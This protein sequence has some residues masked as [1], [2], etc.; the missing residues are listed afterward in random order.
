MELCRLNIYAFDGRVIN[1]ACINQEATRPNKRVACS[2]CNNNKFYSGRISIFLKLLFIDVLTIIVNANEI[3]M[4]VIS[5][6]IFI[7]KNGRN[8]ADGPAWKPNE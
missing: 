3:W 6:N 8:F 2:A 4:A 1:N 5:S 7:Q